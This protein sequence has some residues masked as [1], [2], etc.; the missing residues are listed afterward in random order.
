MSQCSCVGRVRFADA[1]AS[2]RPFGRSAFFDILIAARGDPPVRQ[3]VRH[4]FGVGGSFSGGG[5]L[6]EGGLVGP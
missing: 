6:G 1:V 5:S 4:G 3:L 2:A